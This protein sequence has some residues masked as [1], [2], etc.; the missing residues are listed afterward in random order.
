MG[1]KEEVCFQDTSLQGG[2]TML[3]ESTTLN[4]ND[5]ANRQFKDFAYY[6]AQFQSASVKQLLK[7]I[8]GT[9]KS[10]KSDQQK[11]QNSSI[12]ALDFKLSVIRAA[13]MK[14]EIAAQKKIQ[15][16]AQKKLLEPS[17]AVTYKDIKRGEISGQLKFTSS[18]KVLP[19]PG[20]VFKV[21][22]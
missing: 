7:D 13:Q 21:A 20:T 1:E 22:D 16:K 18:V 5:G 19:L 14:A 9:F 4:N 8:K 15:K 17:K 11:K 3:A 10:A 6:Q 12:G 2:K